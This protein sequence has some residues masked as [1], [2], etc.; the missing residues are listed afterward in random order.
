MSPRRPSG[1]AGAR[2]DARLYRPRPVAVELAGEAPRD[3]SREI[4]AGAGAAG[5]RAEGRP[6]AAGRGIPIRVAG[7][8]V[9]AIRE[10]WLV[11]DRWWTSRPLRRRYYELVL[12]DGRCVVVFRDLERGGWF[13]QRA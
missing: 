13:S 8:P 4:A 12:A 11:E 10:E 2:R 9:E 6:P 7:S 5:P 1:R 3:R